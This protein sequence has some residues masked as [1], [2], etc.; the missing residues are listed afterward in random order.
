MIVINE[1]TLIKSN[2]NY[3]DQCRNQKCLLHNYLNRYL[4]Y[5]CLLFYRSIN[6]KCVRYSHQK[7]HKTKK[8]I[9]NGIHRCKNDN[10][11]LKNLKN[12]LV[13]DCG[14][15]AD[16]EPIYKDILRGE[17]YLPCSWSNQL[18]CVPGHPKCYHFSQICI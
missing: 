13:S 10:I 14:L 11:I 15:S 6:G 1:T 8:G 5:C 9:S 3:L 4:D 7:Y 12:D 2:S 18:Q 16:D 17:M